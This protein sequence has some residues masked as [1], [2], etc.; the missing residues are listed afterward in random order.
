MGSTDFKDLPKT[1]DK[2]LETA[3]M[4][5]TNAAHLAKLLKKE[6]LPAAT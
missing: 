6:P 4:T 2:V 1:P 5:A 3:L